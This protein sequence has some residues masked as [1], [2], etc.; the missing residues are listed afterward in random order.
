MVFPAQRMRMSGAMAMQ[1]VW[2]SARRPSPLNNGLV[3]WRH[4]HPWVTSGLCWHGVGKVGSLVIPLLS[5]RA[6][7]PQDTLATG[8]VRG[9]FPLP[10]TFPPE[11]LG[12]GSF[13]KLADD[14][15]LVIQC[16]LA[17][18]CSALNWQ[19]GYRSNSV[20]VRSGKVHV[21]VRQQ[22][23]NNISRF[24]EGCPH[25]QLSYDDVVRDLKGRKISYTGEEIAQPGEELAVFNL[26]HERG[27]I[28][29]VDSSVAYSDEKGCYLSGMFGVVKQGRYTSS[30]L[31]V[32][33]CIMNL[34]PVNAIL[35][36]V[37]GDIRL[38]PGA[39]NW[40]PL[41]LDGGEEVWI[42]QSDMQSAFY[43]FSVPSELYPFL[44]FNYEVD[45]K[46]VGLPQAGK[47]RPCC[48]VLPMGWSSSVGLMQMMSRE[49][50]LAK[51]LPPELELNKQTGAPAWFAQV[52]SSATPTRAWWQVYLDNFMCQRKFP[53][54]AIRK[55]TSPF[56]K[57]LLRPGSRRA[58]WRLRTR[59]F[60]VLAWPLNWGYELM[61]LEAC[62][63]LLRK[64][65]LRPWWLQSS[66]WQALSGVRSMLKSPPIP[67]KRLITRMGT[68]TGRCLSSCNELIRDLPDQANPVETA[69]AP[70]VSDASEHVTS[71]SCTRR[72]SA[73]RIGPKDAAKPSSNLC[74][75]T[76]IREGQGASTAAQDLERSTWPDVMELH[77][78]LN[79]DLREVQRW[80]NLFG[81]VAEVH[82]YAGFPCIHLSSVRAGRLNLQGDGSN[83][84]WHLLQV[85]DWVIQVFGT[86]CKVKWC[87]ENVA[88]MDEEARKEIS[89]HLEVQP[90]KFD[91]ADCSSFSRPRFAWC[92][93]EIFEMEGLTLFR[94]K[95]YI[96]AF[97]EA[98]CPPVHA[99]IRPSWTWPAKQ[100]GV[101]FPTL[102]K[103]IPRSRPPVRPAGLER[104]GPA[105]RE[106]WIQ[107][108]FRYPPYQYS[109]QFML[110]HSQFPPRVLDS[111]EREL[112][113]GFGA[114]HTASCMSA[115]NI[116][117]SK[118][119]YEDCRKTLCGDSFA[120]MSFAIVGAVLCQDLAPRMPPAQI[121]QRLG[122]APGWS[123]HP[124]V[125]VPM[126]RWLAYHSTCTSSAS[127]VDLARY[128]GLTVNH[129]G[130]D[131]RILTGQPIDPWVRPSVVVA[132]ETTVHTSVETT[133]TYQPL[134]NADDFKY[135]LVEM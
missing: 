43:L 122:L 6:G 42:S 73:C 51:G 121:A 20:V 17:S 27:I 11:L 13:K 89:N 131:I 69:A 104:V 135:Y 125:T 83:L 14:P 4:A 52:V 114:H 124:S 41:T 44:C 35:S 106:R 62:L 108:S 101:R 113:L 102:K 26:L 61:V 47:V 97:V 31:P 115:S 76:S 2:R 123:A 109:P 23:E 57:P 117:K 9:L 77:D 70:P 54:S 29:W 28:N 39:Q 8:R 18:V 45:A 56:T 120:M 87:V 50:L 16:W 127:G 126:T 99:W 95:E 30:G 24:L 103:S 96:R 98:P 49:I 63:G 105:T 34:V 91:P 60:S 110:V 53:V 118:Q 100:E 48:R 67:L 58:C 66:I 107:D 112:L 68:A 82:L 19:Y 94:E 12:A 64:D 130:S 128:L 90:V 92:S 132:M 74:K 86:F 93:E 65:S 119:A 55:K 32:L 1:A 79:I 72:R 25:L 5:N 37:D 33:R 80:A 71:E 38:L 129:T 36:V 75:E 59:V 85:M 88:S 46:L 134:G 10:V 84:F 21:R 22:L 116:K 78:I 3:N 111:S 15:K 133:V 40:L 81:R 7:S